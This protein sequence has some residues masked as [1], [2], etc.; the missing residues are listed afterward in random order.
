[1]DILYIDKIDGEVSQ[2]LY[3]LPFGNLNHLPMT[4][5]FLFEKRLPYITKYKNLYLCSA[6]TYPGGQVTGI[7]AYNVANLILSPL[8]G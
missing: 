8:S 2:Q 7:P 5:D 6:G 3:N 4:D 1:E